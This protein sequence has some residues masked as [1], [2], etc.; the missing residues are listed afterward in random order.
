MLCT[1]D[2]TGDNGFEASNVS[3]AAWPEGFTASSL[4]M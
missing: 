2:G 1:F 4:I 3:T